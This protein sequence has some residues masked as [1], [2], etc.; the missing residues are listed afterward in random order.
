MP[1]PPNTFP[2]QPSTSPGRF[3]LLRQILLFIGVFFLVLLL[4]F[5][6]YVVIAVTENEWMSN[7]HSS[8]PSVSVLSDSLVQQE[9]GSWV[10]DSPSIQE[11]LA[12]GGKWALLLDANGSVVWSYN[13][14]ADI[15]DT[16]TRNEVAVMAHSSSYASYPVFVWTKDSYLTVLG[17]PPDTYRSVG[18]T[19]PQETFDRLPLYILLVLLVD[20]L[21]FFLFYLISRHQTI[22]YITPALG[23]LDQLAQG[24]PT[25]LRLAG[26][27]R[28]IGNKINRVSDTL[29][30]KEKARKNWVE[31]ISHDVR[32][33]LA[34]IMGRA[35][36][37]QRATSDASI[38]ASAG[39]IVVQSTRIRDLV[40]DLNIATQLE[41]DMQP[42]R[43]DQ[44]EV[45]RILR[46]VVAEN[47]N[48]SDESPY[49]FEVTVAPE[50]QPVRLMGD[51]KLLVRAFQNAI[52]NSIKH[53]PAGCTI[54]ASLSV[55][56]GYLVITFA[57][58]GRGMTKQSLDELVEHLQ[59]DIAERV[60]VARAFPAVP[61]APSRPPAAHAFNA[62]P[63]F[64]APNEDTPLPES[65][66]SFA[67]YP[68]LDPLGE[69]PVPPQ[70]TQSTISA[71]RAEKS[72]AWQ[73]AQKRIMGMEQASPLRE[74]G[75]CDEDAVR[76]VIRHKDEHPSWW[77]G[78][79]TL[80]TKSR[81]EPHSAP[82]GIPTIATSAPTGAP[83][84][85]F[86]TSAAPLSPDE[87][88]KQ[89]CKP[90]WNDPANGP[91]IS[92]QK[93]T[94][95]E[96]PAPTAPSGYEPP[97]ITQE[98]TIPREEPGG[99]RMVHTQ[100]ASV[101]K[102]GLGTSLITH[103]VLSHG[104]LVVFGSK[105]DEGFWIKILFDLRS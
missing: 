105:A 71:Q 73:A 15:P 43:H 42:L 68:Y 9:D 2:V 104:G 88:R 101:R 25:T 81:P 90:Y 40:E 16:I 4:D 10:L 74:G 8:Q 19:L 93:G 100:R 60:E 41:Y 67:P 95:A 22:K 26:P 89:A 97:L 92:G 38:A 58:D 78:S 39:N 66:P 5:V 14:P 24:R 87:A 3:F 63:A 45:A 37:I 76:E 49:R 32:T 91:L 84:A 28:T 12:Q 44:L 59:R 17:F 56:S 50:A 82:E 53:N 103:I 98:R 79:S 29:L 85:H 36:Q 34:V 54:A 77:Y 1:Y 72:R 62:P 13:K 86:S 80:Q 102:Y 48:R 21:I 11:Q 7:A 83:S 57:D 35:E 18:I 75:V 6:L 99:E 33:P 65:S 30:R 31:G 20:A 27:L 96:G 51:E 61:G 70:G 69:G 55:C 52:N 94:P 64:F 23:A 47:L 46:D